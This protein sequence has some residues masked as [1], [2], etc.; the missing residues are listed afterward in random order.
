MAH[1]FTGPK[2]TLEIDDLTE[3]QA[4]AIREEGLNIAGLSQEQDVRD[5]DT[6]GTEVKADKSSDEGQAL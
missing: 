3:T 4:A 5:K 1:R 2:M 6:V